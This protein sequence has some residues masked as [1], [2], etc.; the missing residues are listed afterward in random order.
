[1]RENVG[2]L[3]PIDAHCKRVGRMALFV[4]TAQY[5]AHQHRIRVHDRA[6][7]LL[8]HPAGSAARAA[9]SGARPLR[10]DG[11]GATRVFLVGIDIHAPP[12]SGLL[13]RISLSRNGL[14][15][16][17]SQPAA[18]AGALSSPRCWRS[19]MITGG[20]SVAD[21]LICWAAA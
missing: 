16:K 8:Q 9:A 10:A 14:R 3:E 11:L 5:S 4:R 12:D 1:M 2:M 18:S 13:P 19:A 7:Q 20:R 6:L 21:A 15:M 17:S